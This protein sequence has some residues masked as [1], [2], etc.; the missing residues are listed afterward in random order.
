MSTHL[1][2]SLARASVFGAAAVTSALFALPANAAFHGGNGLIAYTGPG[3]GPTCVLGDPTCGVAVWTVQPD[4]SHPHKIAANSEKPNWSPFGSELAVQ[5]NDPNGNSQYTDLL[6]PG[7]E[8]EFG[9][10][11]PGPQ[12]LSPAFSG[13]AK[14]VFVM[15]DGGIA[16]AA[17]V[18][19]AELVQIIQAG[20]SPASSGSD[21][22]AYERGGDI[23]TADQNGR[24]IRRV[25]KTRAREGAP[26]WSPS[27]KQIVF[28]RGAVN[29][30]QIWVMNA[31]GTHQRRLTHGADD[32]GP[33]YSPDGKFIVFSRFAR[34]M[35]MNA[36]GTGIHQIA[37]QGLDADWQPVR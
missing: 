11:T 14:H 4:G 26:N 27:G 1:S 5:Y 21:E 2:R 15:R 17:R 28:T 37:A 6:R 18:G 19:Q 23:W 20:N 9:Q 32:A 3:G 10:L 13:D 24:H 12:D 25:T 7:G 29:H 16:R 36:N 34:L 22:L 33:A 30:R 8:F 31:N 35:V